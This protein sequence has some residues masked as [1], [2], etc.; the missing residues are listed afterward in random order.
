MMTETNSS[1]ARSGR[2]TEGVR[3]VRFHHITV[4]VRDLAEAVADY[5]GKLGWEPGSVTDSAARFPLDDAYLE[6]TPAGDGV[7]A[8][9]QSVGVVVDDVAS[10]VRQVASAGGAVMPASDGTAT[11]DPASL[12]GVRL[13]FRPA[14]DAGQLDR[15]RPYR[16]INHVVVAV[17]DGEAALRAWAT[18]LGTLPS[19]I[20]LPNETAHHLPVGIAWFGITSD[21]TN[22]GAVSNFVAKRGEGVYAVG[23]VVDD[24]PAQAAALAARG[25]RLIRQESSGQTFLHPATTHGILVDLLPERVLTT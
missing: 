21:G 24:Q 20:G 22:A 8:G 19:T 18:T 4:A 15:D 12:T 3:L 2:D 14:D 1:G 17:A 16:R 5:R 7:P 6:L 11:V 10:A 9:V 13:V 23:L 25:A